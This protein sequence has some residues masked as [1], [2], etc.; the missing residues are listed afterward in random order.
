MIFDSCSAAILSG[1]QG[2]RM[3]RQ[4]KG[5]LLYQ[6]KPMVSYVAHALRPCAESLCINANRNIS[7]YA[8]LGFKVIEDACEASGKGPLSGLFSCL[9]SAS[10]TH[11]IISPCDTPLISCQAFEALQQACKNSPE[12]IHFLSTSSGKHP[13]HA[14]LPVDSALKALV[15]FFE[16]SER[17]SVMAFYDSFSYQ[18]VLWENEEELLNVNT[19]EQ[20]Y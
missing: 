6:G 8:S 14:I 20:L 1:G 2:E 16:Q 15:T 3:G 7:D 17:F 5:L 10:S 11:L 13:L 4:D 19:L 12:Y 18:P 9:K